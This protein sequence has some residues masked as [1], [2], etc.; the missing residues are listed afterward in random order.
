MCGCDCGCGEILESCVV[1][2]VVVGAW[3]S[4]R[5]CVLKV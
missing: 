2:V 1:V 4:I 5:T 3:N